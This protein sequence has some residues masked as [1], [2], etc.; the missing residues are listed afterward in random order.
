MFGKVD[1]ASF[2]AHWNYTGSPKGI[3]VPQRI[4]LA[5]ASGDIYAEIEKLKPT[6]RMYLALKQELARYRLAAATAE[7][8]H[9]R[10]RKSDRAGHAR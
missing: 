1:A 2:D 3:D 9:H 6:H 7:S 8:G 5:L 4:E 10:V